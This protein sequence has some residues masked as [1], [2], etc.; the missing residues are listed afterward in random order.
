MKNSPCGL[1]H[2]PRASLGFSHH[3]MSSLFSPAKW[4]A[5]DGN[6]NVRITDTINNILGSA[7][8]LSFPPAVFFHLCENRLFPINSIYIRTVV[9]IWQMLL[10]TSS[11]WGVVQEIAWDPRHPLIS[12]RLEEGTGGKL[13]LG[14]DL[15]QVSHRAGL[16]LPQYTDCPLWPLPEFNF[17][18]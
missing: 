8:N 9:A 17:G 2:W 7:P 12:N 5:T 11:V 10:I 14:G 6:I 1:S 13:F 3:R 18:F 4:L 15:L 16:K